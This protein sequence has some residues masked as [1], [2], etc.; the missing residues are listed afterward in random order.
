MFWTEL[1]NES[2]YKA[3][4]GGIRLRLPELQ[5]SDDEV[6]RI[7]ATGELQDRCKEVDEVL[8]H[9][10]LPFVPEI[11]QTKLISRHHNDFLAGHFGINK[12]RELVGQK[13][14]W[15]SLRKNVEAYCNAKVTRP[16]ITWPTNLIQ[17]SYF[18]SNQH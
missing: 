10:R 16:L 6:Q 15:P 18:V 9:Q 13:Y 7:K 14:Y 8:H 11:I 2:F 4:I 17:R 5:E 12:T 1:A 3:S